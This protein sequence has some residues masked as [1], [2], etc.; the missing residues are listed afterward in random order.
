MYKKSRLQKAVILFLLLCTVLTG[1][2]SQKNSSSSNGSSARKDKGVRKVII[3]T[4]GTYQPFNYKDEKNQ[5]TGYDID[6]V[7]EIDKRLD[8]VE[9]GYVAAQW[10]SL[11]L[12]LESRKYDMIADQI[13]KDEEREEKY[14]F[15][16]NSYFNSVASLIIRD[17]NDTIKTMDDLKGRKV[18]VSVGTTFAQIL[19]K[20]N[21]EHDSPIS[22]EYYEGNISSVM[23]DIEAG[24]LDATI[25]DKVIAKEHIK[26]L[27]LKLKT[28]G[29]PVIT[30]P[31]YF[32][33]RKGSDSE[34]LR[35]KVDEALSEMRAD[36]T[37]SEISVKWFGEDFTA[38]KQQGQQQAG[39]EKKGNVSE[40]LDVKYM[41]KSFPEILRYAPVTLMIALVSMLVGLIIGLI[42]AL[43]KIYRIPV[44]KWLA[45]FYVS[46]V[47][48]TPLLVQMYLSYYGIPKILGF[49]QSHYQWNIDVSNIP[50]IVFVYI[51]FSLNTGAYLSETIRSAI[52][53][54][55]KGQ[56]EA[57]YSVGMSRFQGM[58]RIVFPQALSIALPNFG[59][60]F[61]SLLKDTS[62]AFI[63]AVVDIMGQAKI[64]GARSLRFF[65]VYI[66]SAIIYW[67]ICLVVGKGVSV[68]EKRANKYEGGMAA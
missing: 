44:L 53:A 46:F 25:N 67:L 30:V 17:D 52:Q 19:E 38:G 3:G 9:F 14:S 22:I 8:D 64:V 39:E 10:D 45:S 36:G 68:M 43:V 23:Q 2:T 56:L 31:S 5:L 47:R 32:V 27:G 66:D 7:K 65:E 4:E 60:S 6:V 49:M 13:S 24:R 57:A 58:V 18:G 16:D 59:N 37:L 63:I 33:F 11:F 55:D 61:I 35:S 48:G 54:V 51:S 28:T 50:A 26:E 34:E 15:P 29:E 42:T 1:C 20:Y 40:L 12:G 21:E 41:V 62:L